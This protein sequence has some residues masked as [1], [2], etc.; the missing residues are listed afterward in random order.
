MPVLYAGVKANVKI[1]PE[2]ISA[3][4]ASQRENVMFII[5]WLQHK[6]LVPDFM[7]HI[8]NAVFSQVSAFY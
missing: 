5:I 3:S 1:A 2:I 4:G 8:M 6:S 7:Q